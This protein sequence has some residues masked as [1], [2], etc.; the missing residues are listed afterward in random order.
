[1]R[2]GI[3]ERIL[4]FRKT[5]LWMAWAAVVSA[6]GGPSTPTPPVTD[7]FPEG[8]QAVCPASPG[9]FTSRDGLATPVTYGTPTTTGG[10]PPVVINCTPQSGSAFPIGTNTVVCTATDARQRTNSCSFT[11]T[12]LTPPKI[13]LT[14]FA[15]FGDSI[16]WGENGAILAQ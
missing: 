10:A 12:V 1:M 16:T 14:R 11:I 8:P 4:S 15:A 5:C 13:S 3:L 2:C 6:C 9:T 7:P